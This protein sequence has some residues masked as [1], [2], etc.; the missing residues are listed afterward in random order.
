M[1]ARQ[2]LVLRV[3]PGITL[4]SESAYYDIVLPSLDRA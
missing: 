3:V 2:R 4:V 1:P